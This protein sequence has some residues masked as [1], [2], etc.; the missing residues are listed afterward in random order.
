MDDEIMKYYHC[1]TDIDY[2]EDD[3]YGPLS[4]E[5]DSDFSEWADKF[6]KKIAYIL[7]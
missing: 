6:A 5:T 3:G 1:L 7:M 2:L 4:Y